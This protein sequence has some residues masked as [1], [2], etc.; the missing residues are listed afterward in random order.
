MAEPTDSVGS[1]TIDRFSGE[2][3]DWALW[4]VRLKSVLDELDLLDIGTGDEPCPTGSGTAEERRKW[5]KRNR[6]LFLFL[7]RVVDDDTAAYLIM[8][9][10]DNDGRDAYDKLQERFRSST[11]AGLNASMLQL[12][13]LR[14]LEGDDPTRV[15]VQQLQINAQL[16]AVGEGFSDRQM[17]VLLLAALPPSYKNF[18][19]KQLGG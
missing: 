19:D 16:K 14:A 2:S 9:A 3:R 6:R 12:F 10:A 18:R 5:I 1:K 8:E 4:S 17:K 13:Q 15:A 11:D 7:T